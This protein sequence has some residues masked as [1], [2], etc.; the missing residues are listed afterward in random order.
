MRAALGSNHTICEA[1]GCDRCPCR[2][3]GGLL[4]AESS[5]VPPNCPNAQRPPSDSSEVVRLLRARKSRVTPRAKLHL[6]NAL[7]T[8]GGPKDLA[9][10]VRAGRLVV[11]EPRRLPALRLNLHRTTH[12]EPMLRGPVAVATRQAWIA[13]KVVH[14]RTNEPFEG[15]RLVVRTPDQTQRAGATGMDGV[16]AVHEIEAGTCEVWCE[17]NGARLAETVGFVTLN[18]PHTTGE[19]N[20]NTGSANNLPD[21]KHD[22]AAAAGSPEITA[23]HQS[24]TAAPDA[25]QV[26]DTRRICPLQTH[27]ATWLAHVLTHQ[28]Q[29]G[30]TLESIAAHYGV[31]EHTLCEF[32]FETTATGAVNRAL[33][34][35]VGCTNVGPDGMSYRFDTG[36]EPGRI[37]VPQRWS[38]QG[39]PTE[40]THVL[41]VD[42]AGGFRLVLENEHN[43]RIP[44]AVYEA[45]FADGAVRQGRL[46]RSGISWIEDP[47]PGT[48]EVTYTDLADVE[49]KSLAACAREAFAE[50]RLAEIYRVL[51]HS[52]PM[53]RRVLAAYDEYFNDHTGGGM[54]QDIEQEFT[55]LDDRIAVEALLRIA[56]LHAGPTSTPTE[57]ASTTSQTEESE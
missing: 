25:A 57:T 5:E 35:R 56:K 41:R 47:A 27:T 11:L 4:I 30:E 29:T 9:Q 28:V 54:L 53:I 8:G 34:D 42:L 51:K 44:E 49:A 21:P 3:R 45:R 55:A 43:L 38:A 2:T 12:A 15:V 24:D 23:A 10:L 13:F 48:V 1:S 6:S 14:H 16:F 20:G 32:N 22:T 40:Q 33:R 26:H 37:F 52:R 7:R 31:D 19:S 36:D 18:A 39:L 46:S 50:R 17:L